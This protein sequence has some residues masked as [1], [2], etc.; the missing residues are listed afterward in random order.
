MGFL[1]IARAKARSNPAFADLKRSE[2]VWVEMSESG[3]FAESGGLLSKEQCSCRQN[4]KTRLTQKIQDSPISVTKMSIYLHFLSQYL[5][6]NVGLTLVN[7][8]QI[9]RLNSKL[10]LKVKNW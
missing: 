9:G 8:Y 6:S 5:Y 2:V 3:F 1:V 10:L 4:P 7:Q